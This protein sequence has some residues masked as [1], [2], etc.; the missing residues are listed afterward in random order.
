MRG[1]L[2]FNAVVVVLVFVFVG[3]VGCVNGLGSMSTI[4]ASYGNG[5]ATV[6]GILSGGQRG[7]Q[8]VQNGQNVMVFPNVSFVGVSGGDGFFCGLRRGG[9]TLLCWNTDTGLSSLQPKRISKNVDLKEIVVGEKHVCGVVNGTGGI[10][11][12]RDE[13]QGRNGSFDSISAGRG[14]TCGI[15]TGNRRVRCWRLNGTEISGLQGP[16]VEMTTVVAGGRDVCGIQDDG[17]VRCWNGSGPVEA[18]AGQFSALALGDG[19]SCGIRQENKTVVCWGDSTPRYSGGDSFEAIVAG[20]NYTCGLVSA[21]FSVMCWGGRGFGSGSILSLPQVLPRPCGSS[22]CSCGEYPNS[23]N[24]CAAESEYICFPCS[25][26]LTTPAPVPSPPPAVPPIVV[27]RGLSRGLLALVIVGC[28]GALAGAATVIWC[29]WRGFYARQRRVHNSV[30]PTVAQLHSGSLRRQTSRAFR[31]QRSGTSS[32]RSKRGDRAEEFTLS[33]LENA[34]GGFSESNIIGAGSFGTVYRGKL[35]DG[36]EVAIKRGDIVVTKKF[37]EKEAA[38]QSELAFLSRLHHKH[39]VS[40]I[41]YCD[42][43]EERMLVYEYMP[44]GALYD[45]LHKNTTSPLLESWTARIKVALDAARGVEYLHTY[46]VPPIIHR[47]I[48]SSNILLDATGTAR[49]SDF[50]LSLMGPEEQGGHL[51]MTAAGTVGYMDPEYYRLHHLTTKTDVY[52][53]G[54]VLL[55]L[56]TGQ[57]AIFKQPAAGPIS[58]VDFA[59]PRIL[60]DELH[61]ILDSRVRPPLSHEIEAVEMV[62]YTAVNCVHLEGK[63]RPSMTDIVA[64]LER[65]VAICMQVPISRSSSLALASPQ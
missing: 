2:G 36:R 30:Q 62:A 14:F 7:I 6:C 52:G 27:R 54:V 26:E 58:V 31:R 19:H 38:F 11:C 28:I 63:D 24:L 17:F 13:A 45:H 41:G 3:L 43:G 42:E 32:N 56:L 21:N 39:L 40:L 44:N 51:S 9:R 61:H 20:D 1:D 35:G 18:R 55:E 4:A 64:N 12:W 15:E 46:A 16:M 50:G 53:F 34:T 59:V 65:A 23:D 8:C 47:D 33:D 48:K 25:P 5:S 22:R 37:Q 10:R 29:L 57:R 60:S 49:V